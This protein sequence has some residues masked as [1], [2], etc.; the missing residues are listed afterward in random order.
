MKSFAFF[1]IHL[2]LFSVLAPNFLLA[3][4]EVKAI[5]SLHHLLSKERDDSIRVRLMVRI[6][7]EYASHVSRPDSALLYYQHALDL[8]RKVKST[9]LQLLVRAR[10]ASLYNSMGNYAKAFEISLDN[11]RLEEQIRDTNE[12]FFTKRE[13]MWAYKN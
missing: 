1:L 7:A 2:V 12:I 8:N 3:Q 10:M 9:S 5:D 6:G 11:L 13:I 4:P